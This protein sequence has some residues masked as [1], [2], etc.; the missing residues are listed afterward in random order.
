MKEMSDDLMK[1]I[2]DL[3]Q[4]ER[5]ETF[6]TGKFECVYKGTSFAEKMKT[7]VG[8]ELAIEGKTV[9]GAKKKKETRQSTRLSALP[10]INI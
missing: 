3:P 8:M 5:P 9:Q 7:F 10:K 6:K 4:S 1:V 2:V